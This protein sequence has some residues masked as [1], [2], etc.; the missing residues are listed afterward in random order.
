MS[1]PRK[2]TRS[3]RKLHA[4]PP[5]I[6]HKIFIEIQNQMPDEHII[7]IINE[8]IAEIDFKRTHGMFQETILT[9]ALNSDLDMLAD[10]ILDITSRENLDVNHANASGETAFLLACKKG[11]KNIA[12]KIASHN[13]KCAPDA[14]EYTALMYACVNVDMI[15]VVTY[16]IKHDLCDVG[17][18]NE[19]GDTALSLTLEIGN[20]KAL[21]ALLESGKSK[22]DHMD[23]KTRVNLFIKTLLDEDTK[24]AKLFLEKTGLACNP[25]IITENNDITAL[26]LSI[27]GKITNKSEDWIEIIRTLLNLAE[28]THNKEYVDIVSAHGPSAFDLIFIY[29]E[30]AGTAIDPRVIKPFLDYYYKNDPNSEVFLRNVDNICQDVEL[31]KAVKR[32]YP[33]KI[34]K[35][36]I[37]NACV[38]LVETK[39]HPI[40]VTAKSRSPTLQT[41]VRTRSSRRFT[42]SRRALQKAEEI[43]IVHAEPA[44][45]EFNVSDPRERGVRMRKIR[46]IQ[47][48][49]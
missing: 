16:I 44:D 1:S 47:N 31:Y 4:D 24:S 7:E 29:A 49:H 28:K 3:K 38:F 6:T 17:H 32:L 2:R 37:K 11:Y 35:K 10:H 42:R 13:P 25:F 40:N 15:D 46:S 22:P 39:A 36:I 20:E 43:P 26:M 33:S 48:S 21:I 30:D 27:P 23:N 9:A 18:V 5:D 14:E 19:N 8:N 41:G 12:L 45:T 34:L